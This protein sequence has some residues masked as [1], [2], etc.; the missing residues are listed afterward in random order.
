MNYWTDNISTTI[1]NK[2]R[3]EISHLEYV[4]I[5]RQVRGNRLLIHGE[6][7]QRMLKQD[8]LKQRPSS[9][10]SF[11]FK[12]HLRGLPC[13]RKGSYFDLTRDIRYIWNSKT[14]IVNRSTQQRPYRRF[15]RQNKSLSTVVQLSCPCW[16]DRIA[17]VRKLDNI[18]WGNASWD[19]WNSPLSQKGK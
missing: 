3:R 6:L 2:K 9:L 15:Y 12:E 14:K 4:F 8:V 10:L 13:Y 1:T 7:Y 18:V 17:C 16:T 19:I 5:S 11:Y